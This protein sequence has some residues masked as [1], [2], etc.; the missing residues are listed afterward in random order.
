METQT[1]QAFGILQTFRK[2]FLGRKSKRNIVVVGLL[3]LAIGYV[4]Y[5]YLGKS[6]AVS[7]EYATATKK[8]IKKNSGR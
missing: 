1:E 8:D 3:T 7:Y 2:I 4:S 6:G 5:A